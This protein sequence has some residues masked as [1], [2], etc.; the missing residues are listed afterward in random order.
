MPEPGNIDSLGTGTQAMEMVPV[1]TQVHGNTEVIDVDETETG[2]MLKEK[3]AKRMK[4]S[5]CS[6]STNKSE[7]EK[8]LAEEVEDPEKEIDILAWWKVNSNR[9]PVLGHMARDVLAI[10]I[11]SV[12]SESAFSTVG[13]IMDDFRT[14]LTPFMLE[15]L[16]CTQDWLRRPTVEITEN[17]EEL[18]IIEKGMVKVTTKLCLHIY[19]YRNS[20][21]LVFFFFDI[22]NVH[23]QNG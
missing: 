3:I 11:T 22:H 13:R 6:T 1:L 21:A 23:S 19:C 10:P 5:N 8:Y 17:T 4:L 16:V 7:L 20:K 2:G 14:S 9:F 15:A 12:A 18:E